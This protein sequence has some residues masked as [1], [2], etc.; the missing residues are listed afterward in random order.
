MSKATPLERIMLGL[1]N[2]ERTG[3]GL[4][5]LRLERRLGEASEDHS[6]WMLAADEFAHAG[7][8]GSSAG[9]RMREAG[10]PFEGAWTWGENIALQSERGAPGLA[11]DV[12]DL[13]RSLMESPGHRAN[14]LKP[15]FEVVGIG[16]ERGEYKGFD[17][18]VA[19]QNFARSEG[20]MRF[21]GPPPW[22]RE[23]DRAVPDPEPTPSVANAA[24]TLE[25]EDF[26]MRPGQFHRLARHVE[27]ADADGD[28]AARYEIEDL[29][30]GARVIVA[31]RTVDARGGHVLDAGDLAG[32]TIRFDPS[33]GE[34]AFRMRAHDGERW[35]NW[36]GFEIRSK[37][38][39]VGVAETSPA[40]AVEARDVVVEAGERIRLA[41]LLEVVTD[42]D[43]VRSFHVRDDEGGPG[44]WIA[45]RGV[46]GASP[47]RWFSARAMDRLFLEADDEPSERTLHVQAYDGE[48]RSAWESFTVT[49]IGWDDL[50]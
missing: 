31:G 35:G 30:G 46:L 49:T 40:L 18:V 36:D 10:F 38:D 1:I 44:L 29:S 15:E 32:L 22:E 43:P 8:G 12:A 28:P 9:D 34:Q 16:V 5:P 27:Y 7:R 13:H 11:D 20:A 17:T 47:D 50:G 26:A 4:G 37:P 23:P 33:G 42:G 39:V 48:D 3:A 14:V 6:R 19:T 24:P 2:E 45:H 21:D 25:V 41:D